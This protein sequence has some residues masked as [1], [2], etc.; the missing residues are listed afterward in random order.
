[1]SSQQL[2]FAQSDPLKSRKKIERKLHD[3]MN[4]EKKVITFL[5]RVKRF[6]R[7][8]EKILYILGVCLKKQK[9]VKAQE[10][11]LPARGSCLSNG[12]VSCAHFS[13]P[14][15]GNCSELER[16]LWMDSF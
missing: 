11:E 1:M 15:D 8:G 4:I 2:K 5:H 7:R 10:F 12:L 3:N 6:A 14:S 9:K 13:K 16:T